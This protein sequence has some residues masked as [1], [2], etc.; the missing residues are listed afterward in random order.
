MASS[1]V[2]TDASGWARI[3]DEADTPQAA[4]DPAAVGRGA[5]EGSQFF[6][7]AQS[8]RRVQVVREVVCPEQDLGPAGIAQLARQQA[9]APGPC[10][11]AKAEDIEEVAQGAQ[12][13]GAGVELF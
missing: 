12:Q 4:G 7:E 6:G 1:Y 2:A 5:P 9:L 8:G 13:S 11:G 3:L 10:L